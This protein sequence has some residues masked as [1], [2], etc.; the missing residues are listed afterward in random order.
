MELRKR[1]MGQRARGLWKARGFPALGM[2]STEGRAEIGLDLEHIIII[3]FKVKVSIIQVGF[4]T[5]R[6]L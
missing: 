5:L 4:E 2:A 1:I 3:S 6:E